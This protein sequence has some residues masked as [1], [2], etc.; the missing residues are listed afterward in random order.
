MMN[1]IIFLVET[2]PDGGFVAQAKQ[3][4]ID[5]QSRAKLSRKRDRN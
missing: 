2:D 3:G 5:D 1:E 4:A